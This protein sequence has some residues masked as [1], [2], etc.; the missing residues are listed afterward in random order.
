MI[1]SLLIPID[2]ST[3]SKRVVR[4]V[5][6]LPLTAGAEL[7]LLHVVPSVLPRAMRLR[8]EADAHRALR[9]AARQLTHDVPRAIVLR[10]TVRMGTAAAEIARQADTL[11]P[12]LIVMGRGGGRA[13]R[14]AFLGSTAERVLRRAQLPVLVVRRP[15]HNAYQRPLLAVDADPAAERI[16]NATLKLL[17]PPRPTLELIHAYDV[18]YDGANYPS[19]SRDS[20][21]KY[22]EEHRQKALR[23]LDGLLAH[24][25]GSLD[26]PTGD[27]VRWKTHVRYG[28]ARRVIPEAVS[29]TQADLLVL[30]TQGRT[31]VAHAFLGSVAG[32]V[33]RDVPCDVLV[34]PPRRSTSAKRE[35]P[36]RSTR[37]RPRAS[38]SEP[39][40][41]SSGGRLP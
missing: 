21:R 14:D 7:T 25:L 15:D 32:D 16:L 26:G 10:H 28:S 35:A 38:T 3:A 13:V 18:S 30:G 29:R 19:L 12:D 20:A 33:L 17:P 24:E 8:A 2:L 31:G 6:H 41:H 40:L 4:R 23:E 36:R 11:V 1:R 22:R 5:A 9:Q 34:V 27:G 37:A 39:G